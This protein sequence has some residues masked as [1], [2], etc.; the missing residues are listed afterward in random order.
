MRLDRRQRELVLKAPAAYSAHMRLRWNS[1][2]DKEV[3]NAISAEID[4]VQELRK[5]ILLEDKPCVSQ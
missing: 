2:L 5:L 3:L 4:N 1:A